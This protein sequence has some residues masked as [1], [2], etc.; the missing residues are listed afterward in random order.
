MQV[1]FSV[2]A[3]L[4]AAA[5]AQQSVPISADE[6]TLRHKIYGTNG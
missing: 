4:A 6:V 1:V 2:R 3:L 5:S